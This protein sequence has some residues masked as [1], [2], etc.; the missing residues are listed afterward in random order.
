MLL[1]LF[2][3]ANLVSCARQI[4]STAA[5]ILDQAFAK[6]ADGFDYENKTGLMEWFQ[7]FP[8]CLI[9]TVLKNRNSSETAR[10]SIEKKEL[11]A[12]NKA[13]VEQ[14]TCRDGEATAHSAPIATNTLRLELGCGRILRI[15][16][17]APKTLFLSSCL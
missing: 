16:Q 1:L 4:F 14:R 3:G 13:E 5:L 6:T 9:I 10:I 11:K 2:E 7:L 17:R 8:K 15:D 12:E